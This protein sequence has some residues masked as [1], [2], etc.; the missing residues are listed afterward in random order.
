[1]DDFNFGMEP[2]ELVHLDVRDTVDTLPLA[3]MPT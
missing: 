2:A 1:M 3:E